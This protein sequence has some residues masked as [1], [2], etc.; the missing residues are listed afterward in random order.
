LLTDLAA[1][2]VTLGACERDL[3][4]EERTAQY[5]RVGHIVRAV[6]DVG[7]LLPAQALHH[8]LAGLCPALGEREGIRVDLAGVQD[9]RQRVDDRHRRRSSELFDDVMPVG[10]DD[11]AVDV[12]REHARGVRD[13]LPA[14]DLRRALVQI[15]G[16]CAEF[17]QADLERHARAGARLGE[18]QAPG[19]PVEG[20]AA[21]LPA[22]GLELP[23]VLEY[24]GGLVAAEVGFLEK[25]AH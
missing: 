18:E 1:G 14:T 3:H 10:A 12:A 20:V 9:V 11:Q 7:Q 17:V 2:A 4:S 25:V 19:L 8:R 15:H 23:C 22:T 13:G 16:M 24:R 6:S 5:P 21:E